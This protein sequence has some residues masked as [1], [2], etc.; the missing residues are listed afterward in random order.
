VIQFTICAAPCICY[1]SIH[2]LSPKYVISLPHFSHDFLFHQLF[3]SSDTSLH[4]RSISKGSVLLHFYPK[5][6]NVLLNLL[7]GAEINL[8]YIKAAK[9][10]GCEIVPSF[11]ILSICNVMHVNTLEVA[12]VTGRNKRCRHVKAGGNWLYST[13]RVSTLPGKVRNR[14]QYSDP[15]NFS[16]TRNP[17]VVAARSWTN[18]L[19]ENHSVRPVFTNALPISSSFK[20]TK[21]D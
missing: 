6:H 18:V 9:Y 19:E 4:P 2:T 3:T 10:V 16:A 15:L 11:D 17:S 1:V 20:E 14:L 5:V 7:S 21:H 8:R 13:C 12:V